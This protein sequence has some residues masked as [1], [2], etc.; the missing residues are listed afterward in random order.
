MEHAM[1]EEERLSRL[2]SRRDKVRVPVTL[3]ATPAGY[4]LYKSLGFE[5]VANVTLNLLD[6]YNGGITWIEYMQWF[7]D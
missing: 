1:E 5:S 6:G 4:P 7:S 3:L 2:D